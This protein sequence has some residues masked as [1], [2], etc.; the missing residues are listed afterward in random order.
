MD[1]R[2][3]HDLQC[4]REHDPDV[5][6]IPDCH[7]RER[8]LEAIVALLTT[9][10]EQ[11]HCGLS[12]TWCPRHRKYHGSLCAFLHTLPDILRIVEP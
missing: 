10:I 9:A 7:C 4:E 5:P 2:L 8:A 12:T 3:A 1:T 6:W 11:H